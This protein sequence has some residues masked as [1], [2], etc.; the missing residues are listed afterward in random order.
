MQTLCAF[1]SLVTFKLND[2]NNASNA[3]LFALIWVKVGNNPQIFESFPQKQR[4]R[5]G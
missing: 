3:L 4:E 5:D 2:T 1:T